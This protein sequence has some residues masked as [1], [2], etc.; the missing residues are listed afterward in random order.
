MAQPRKQVSS[1]NNSTL[2]G[3]SK[4]GNNNFPLRH[5]IAFIASVKFLNIKDADKD[6]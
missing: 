5:W 4:E 1:L 6:L 3:S 2:K